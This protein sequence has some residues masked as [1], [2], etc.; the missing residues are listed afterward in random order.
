MEQNISLDLNSKSD[1]SH[2]CPRCGRSYQNQ[3]TLNR[4]FRSHF[5]GYSK[6]IRRVENSS[7]EGATC[8]VCGKHYAL[9][10]SLKRH[11]QTHNT[12]LKY[13][14]QGCRTMFVTYS[15]MYKHRMNCKIYKG[16]Q[17]IKNLAEKTTPWIETTEEYLTVYKHKCQMCDARFALREQL[18]DHVNHCGD[19]FVFPNII[20]KIP[21][22]ASVSSL[23]KKERQKLKLVE[24]RK[25]LIV[26]VAKKVSKWTRVKQNS[27]VK[28]CAGINQIL[29]IK[30]VFPET[31]ARIMAKLKVKRYTALVRRKYSAELLVQFRKTKKWTL[32]K[33][34]QFRHSLHRNHSYKCLCGRIFYN[35]VTVVKHLLVYHRI[36]KPLIC[37]LCFKDF[38]CV[39][40]FRFHQ[41]RHENRTD[42]ENVILRYTTIVCKRITTKRHRAETVS[43][44]RVDLCKS[45]SSHNKDE[46][47]HVVKIIS[48]CNVKKRKRNYYTNKI[49][50]GNLESKCLCGKIFMKRKILAHHVQSEHNLIMGYKC[51]HCAGSNAFNTFKD[52]YT[53]IQYKHCSI[54][55]Q[56]SDFEQMFL[57]P[58]VPKK[59]I[60]A[61]K[62][63]LEVEGKYENTC[64]KSPLPVKKNMPDPEKKIPIS[65]LR[66]T[67]QRKPKSVVNDI[68]IISAAKDEAKKALKNEKNNSDLTQNNPLKNKH[69]TP[70]KKSGCHTNKLKQKYQINSKEFRANLIVRKYKTLL[71]GK[72]KVAGKQSERQ[73]GERKLKKQKRALLCEQSLHQK[74]RYKCSFC[75]QIFK[76]AHNVISHLSV[77]HK[78]HRVLECG[79]CKKIF[80]VWVNM[81]I[82]LFQHNKLSKQTTFSIL[83]TTPV[84]P[85][86]KDKMLDKETVKLT[87]GKGD[88]KCQMCGKV[89]LQRIK[90]DQHL[91]TSH[92]MVLGYRCKL[93]NERQFF[94]SFER[95][96][97]HLG[98]THNKI[99][100][101]ENDYEQLYVKLYAI[102]TD[103][104][105]SYPKPVYS[106]PPGT[107][108]MGNTKPNLIKIRTLT[109]PSQK[110]HE[111]THL[112]QNSSKPRVITKSA[113]SAHASRSEVDSEF[114]EKKE[115]QMKS[116]VPKI[117]RKETGK[118]KLKI[119]FDSDY[120]YS[121]GLTFLTKKRKLCETDMSKSDIVYSASDEMSV[122]GV[123]RQHITANTKPDKVARS[124]PKS[125]D[126]SC[127]KYCG[128]KFNDKMQLQKHIE[129]L[130][131]KDNE[132]MFRERNTKTKEVANVEAN[133]E[134]NCC[135]KE[136]RV[137]L[138]DISELVNDKSLSVENLDFTERKKC[139]K[140]MKD[141]KMSA[142]V[143]QNDQ[144]DTGIRD[145]EIKNAFNDSSTNL[146]LYRELPQTKTLS[147]LE[148]VEEGG[149]V[150]FECTVKNCNKVFSTKKK[151]RYHKKE[152]HCKALV[153]IC[154]VC[155]RE[156]MNIRSIKI[157]VNNSHS[158]VKTVPLKIEETEFYINN[159]HNTFQCPLK[160][161]AIEFYIKNEQPTQILVCTT[162]G[163]IGNDKVLLSHT[164]QPKGLKYYCPFCNMKRYTTVFEEI[165]DHIK[166]KHP[167]AIESAKERS[168]HTDADEEILSTDKQNAG[169]KN[170]PDSTSDVADGEV[171]FYTST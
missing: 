43:N 139:C 84:L 137:L 37:G 58:L 152:S 150:F 99:N 24:Q 105:S 62:T 46:S 27:K 86:L 31:S 96:S 57:I 26:Q 164:C 66:N 71:E 157:H 12:S 131:S 118:R 142:V 15:Q 44:D 151:L 45:N 51:T 64:R 79:I 132:K 144:S 156:Y 91:K 102:K 21:E 29:K 77:A 18:D 30:Q 81:N 20:E 52:L 87:H 147:H 69:V 127:C 110:D 3:A 130:H 109:R 5:L 143:V 163:T 124:C 170:S 4:H 40:N 68:N 34:T 106:I 82:H 141:D 56:Q 11:M 100:I 128:K 22:N 32:R 154:S 97:E 168:S 39:T 9:K 80:S 120:D 123:K 122:S 148:M 54:N 134:Q 23:L 125:R 169:E 90:L 75:Q 108:S 94:A 92:K 6:Q 98:A 35:L 135:T 13:Y 146:K 47:L 38:G 63:M 8:S 42:T 171:R 55:I 88:N 166:C 7:S 70:A 59:E 158:D 103:A 95:F 25:K 2:T 41:Y 129:K 1:G 145:N 50:A 160:T 161:E 140:T 162:C 149:F 113:E 117:G 28:T 60:T 111:F 133:L 76:D 61:D 74:C 121:G 112:G 72:N 48:M 126:D 116:P 10:D 53:H 104:Q 16:S 165:R 107:Q 101:A 36:E 167:D 14:C 85:G 78:E 114:Y 115:K 19:P 73:H 33:K 67:E 153:Y 119:K 83:Y 93:C 49:L 65:A 17:E 155:F 89:F 138:E 159:D 136:L